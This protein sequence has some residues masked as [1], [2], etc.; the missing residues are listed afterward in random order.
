MSDTLRDRIAKVIADYLDGELNWGDD[1]APYLADAVIEALGLHI[2]WGALDEQ[3]GGL[4]A[5][6]RDKLLPLHNRECIKSRYV[7]EWVKR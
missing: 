1:L 7:T 5:D 6:S 3:D 4:I 2:E